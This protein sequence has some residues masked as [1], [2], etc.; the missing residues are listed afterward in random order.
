MEQPE[1]KSSKIFSTLMTTST[2]PSRNP[3]ELATRSKPFLFAAAFGTARDTRHTSS[4]PTNLNLDG[5]CSP[6]GRVAIEQ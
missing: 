2:R 5:C 6:T 1:L 4:R 3:Q